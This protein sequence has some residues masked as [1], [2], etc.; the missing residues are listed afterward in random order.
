MNTQITTITKL[1]NQCYK[2]RLLT[3]YSGFPGGS[4]VKN[5][6][7]NAGDMGSILGWEDP[8]EKE[9]VTHSSFPAMDRGGWQAAVHGVAK[10]SNTT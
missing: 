10:E 8:L 1:L 6:T 2:V 4:V 3:Q 5:P 9:M 7:A